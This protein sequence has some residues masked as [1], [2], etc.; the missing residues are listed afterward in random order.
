MKYRYLLVLLFFLFQPKIEAKTKKQE[1]QQPLYPLQA[2]LVKNSK[3]QHELYI[4]VVNQGENPVRKRSIQVTINNAPYQGLIYTKTT[5]GYSLHH[6]LYAGELGAIIIPI[7]QHSWQQC[8]LLS[9]A[10]AIG[11]NTNSPLHQILDF[12][13]GPPNQLRLRDTAYASTCNHLD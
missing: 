10:L 9:V 13:Y 4:T 5:M 6:P 1:D 2:F 11:A 7:K 8:E 3:H 12:V